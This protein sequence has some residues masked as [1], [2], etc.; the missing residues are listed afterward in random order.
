MI[1]NFLII[2]IF[3]GLGSAARYGVSLLLRGSRVSFSMFSGIVLGTLLVNVLG[4]F[5]LGVALGVVGTGLGGSSYSSGS[6]W[7]WLASVGFCGGFTTFSTFSVEA[8][9]LVMAGRWAEAGVYG[10]VSCVVCVA[11]AWGGVVLGPV[12]LRNCLNL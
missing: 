3:G 1:A 2:A 8:V 12:L 4:S 10:V 11:A 5:L 9:E 7:L 6:S